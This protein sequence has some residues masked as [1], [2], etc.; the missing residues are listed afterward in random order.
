[1]E[2][3]GF[4]RVVPFGG[5]IVIASVNGCY[6]DYVAAEFFGLHDSAELHVELGMRMPPAIKAVAERYYGGVSTLRNI[7]VHGDVGWR[8]RK[9]RSLAWFKAMAP[10]EINSRSAQKKK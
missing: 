6:A 3:D 1:M 9:S 4:A 8:G 10:F 5:G 7:D 2:G